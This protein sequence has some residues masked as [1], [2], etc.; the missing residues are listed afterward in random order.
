M[1]LPYSGRVALPISSACSRKYRSPVESL[2]SPC[3]TPAW[4]GCTQS[5]REH[6]GLH[7]LHCE[8]VFPL[9][10]GSLFAASGDGWHSSCPQELSAEG[11]QKAEEF[12][13]THVPACHRI[14]RSLLWS[15]KELLI[16]YV[17]S[18]L[19]H[20]LPAKTLDSVGPSRMH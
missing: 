20:I 3:R 8:K 9:S 19:L 1:K 18:R 12:M 10:A 4:W 17:C 15:R 11:S 2:G 14:L 7:I 13:K 6:T 16:C 5:S